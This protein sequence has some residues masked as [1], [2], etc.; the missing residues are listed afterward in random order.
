MTTPM[1]GSGGFNFRNLKDVTYTIRVAIRGYELVA[2]FVNLDSQKTR[3]FI[4]LKPVK[5]AAAARILGGQVVNVESAFEAQPQQAV[6]SYR[7][8][9]DNHRKNK[10]D[11]AMRQLKQVLHM[12]PQFFAAH[13]GLG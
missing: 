8:A 10:I 2:Q 7:K 6:E 13:L 9:L 1:D 5:S 11:E 4:E 12:A 3:V